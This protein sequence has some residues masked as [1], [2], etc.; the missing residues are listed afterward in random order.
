MVRFSSSSAGQRVTG[1]KRSCRQ[2]AGQ[3]LSILL[4]GWATKKV[5]GLGLRLTEGGGG[6]GR[7]SGGRQHP[8]IH[9]GREYSSDDRGQQVQPQLI[10]LAGDQGRADGTGGID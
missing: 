9:L 5:N 3:H 7:R 2:S 8:V 6:S 10:Q 4:D 1:G